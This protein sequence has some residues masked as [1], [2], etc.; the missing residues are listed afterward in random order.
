MLARAV[1]DHRCALRTDRAAVAR[2]ALDQG[3]K[4]GL[5]RRVSPITDELD[6]A[7]VI[8]HCQ[9]SSRDIGRRVGSKH[10]F[11]SSLLGANSLQ[12]LLERRPDEERSEQCRVPLDCC[13]G[14]PVEL[15]TLEGLREAVST[16]ESVEISS[17][18][19]KTSQ[20]SLSTITEMMAL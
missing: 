11:R 7:F 19:N 5:M 20:P 14:V 1:A 15:D 6:K 3:I 12:K 10:G 9:N 4:L 16:S 17:V 13:I 8:W 18:A 2:R